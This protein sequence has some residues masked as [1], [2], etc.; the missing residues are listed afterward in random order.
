MTA[1]PSA[2]DD[3]DATA[4]GLD[5]ARATRLISSEAAATAGTWLF[6]FLL[7]FLLSLDGAGYWPTAWAWTALF[8]CALILVLRPEVRLGRVELVVPAALLGLAAWGVAS[9]LWASSATQ[10]FLQS[11]RTLMY[12]AVAF[13]TRFD[14]SVTTAHRRV[15][16][17]VVD[18][19]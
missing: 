6:A 13:A 17:R 1:V 4:V 12:A 18:P 10:P 8:L 15:H 14:C 16:D 5:S 9:A 3:V 11:Q 19:G 7:V 2:A